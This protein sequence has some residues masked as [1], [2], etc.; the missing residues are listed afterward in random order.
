M[1]KNDTDKVTLSKSSFENEVLDAFVRLSASLYTLNT[2]VALETGLTMSEL[3]AS[4]HLRLDGPLSPKEISKRI[5]LSTGATTGMLDRLEQRGFIKRTPHPTDRRSVLVHYLEPES[6]SNVKLEH[7]Q[8]LL[9]MRIEKLGEPQ[10]AAVA[11][12]L[13]GVSGDISRVS[14][15]S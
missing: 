12:F 3:A 11:S 14:G 7:L 13:R 15:E 1:K 2:L 4:E 6:P 5:H 9:E 8:K 10:K